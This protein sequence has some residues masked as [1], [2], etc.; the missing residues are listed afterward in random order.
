M[1]EMQHILQKTTITEWKTRVTAA[2]NERS[3]QHCTEERFHD[4]LM[5]I[6][7]HDIAGYLL[8]KNLIR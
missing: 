7:A 1:E 6:P 3:Y 4:L 2:T 8:H 5:N